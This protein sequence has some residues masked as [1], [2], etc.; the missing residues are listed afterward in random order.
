MASRGSHG[1]YNDSAATCPAVPD[2]P[3]DSATAIVSARVLLFGLG[4]V[5]FGVLIA[6]VTGRLGRGVNEVENHHQRELLA[7]ALALVSTDPPTIRAGD[8]IDLCPAILSAMAR[9]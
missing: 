7:R 1:R 9:R 6:G 4:Q 5:D 2:A 8:A 3:G